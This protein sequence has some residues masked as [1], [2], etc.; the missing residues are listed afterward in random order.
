MATPRVEDMTLR[1]YYAAAIVSGRLDHLVFVAS[2]DAP[3]DLDYE[4]EVLADL[5]YK[6]ADA[7]LQARPEEDLLG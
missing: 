6:L 4:V 1:D 7:M 5:A 2:H 3:P